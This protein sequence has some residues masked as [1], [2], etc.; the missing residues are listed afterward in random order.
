MKI[1]ELRAENFKRLRAVEIAPDGTVQVIG[2]RNAQGKSSVLDAIWAALGGGKANPGKPIRDGEDRAQVT[3]NLGDLTITR[4]WTKA[5]TTLKV[6]NADGAAYKSPQGMLDTLI[7]QL[8]FDPLAFTRLAPRQQREE[9]LRLV[10]LPIDL[11]NLEAERARMYAER[12]EL[13]RRGKAI[14]DVTVDD[15]LPTDET[16][17]SDLIDQIDAAQD[18]ARHNDEVKQ[19][20]RRAAEHIADLKNMIADLNRK[21]VD[22]QVAYQ[23]LDTEYQALPAPADVKDLRGRLSEVEDLNQ[24]IRANNQARERKAEQDALRAEYEKHTAALADLDKE[25]A[26]A[27]T[28]AKFP[29]TGLGF[30]EHGVTYQG[31][32]LD[33]AS[34]AEQIRASLAMG[35][36][37]NPKLRVLMI[38]DG[39]LLDAESM[40]AI[41]DQV[42]EHGFQLWIERVGDADQGAVVIEDGAVK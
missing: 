10:D 2:G 31:V 20:H 23:A 9:L 32:P 40:A 13:G 30:D 33:Q 11:D 12:T 21:L 36:A 41:H 17:A 29:V 25:K 8:G 7:G 39:S 15:E 14:G 5:G 27:L 18:V 22:A 19:A 26:D 3:L 16:S 35:M 24:R 28:A 4:T 37:L 6:E 1:I 42:A 38:K 34:S